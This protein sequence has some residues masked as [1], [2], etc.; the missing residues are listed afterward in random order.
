MSQV[1]P[2]IEFDIQVLKQINVRLQVG[3]V[4]KG[5]QSRR[6]NS[7][8]LNPDKQHYKSNITLMIHY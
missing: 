5:M 8:E 6:E 3:L 7:S 1:I 4:I 2:R